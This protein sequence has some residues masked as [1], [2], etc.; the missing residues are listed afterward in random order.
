MKN[1]LFG[2]PFKTISNL[3]LLDLAEKFNI[4]LNDVIMKDQIPE[5][6]LNGNYIINLND[7]GE[8]GS[9]WT[10]FHKDGTTIFWF[11]SFGMPPVQR[12]VDILEKTPP[13]DYLH[14]N[15]NTIQNIKSTMC[16]FYC[17][18]FFLAL[19]HFKGTKKERIHTFQRMFNLADTKVN[20]KILKEF[21]LKSSYNIK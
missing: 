17:L 13:V 15:S 19:K 18:G 5:H 7:S 11:D 6:I 3:S 21:L 20:D 9:H 4:K 2:I 14:Y 8:S 1:S 12:I 16:G 10:C